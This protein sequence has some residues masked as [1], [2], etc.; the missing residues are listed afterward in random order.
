VD[1]YPDK[2]TV[3]F[4]GD[5]VGSALVIQRFPRKFFGRFV[6]GDSFDSHRTLFDDAVKWDNQVEDK[7]GINYPA[8]HRWIE[9][10]G[11]ITRHITLP[12]VPFAMEEFALSEDL[13]LEVTF[14]E[15]TSSAQVT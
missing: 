7:S 15:T 8:W 13:G 1:S 9:I 6:P 2:L 5:A 10:V 14:A 4:D 11:E 12:E 3:L